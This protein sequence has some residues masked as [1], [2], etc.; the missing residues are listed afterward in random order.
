MTRPVD[1]PLI[2][3]CVPTVNRLSYLEDALVSVVQQ[4]ARNWELVVGENSADPEYG[5]RVDH[6]IATRTVGLPNSIRV[7]HQTHQLT[8][9]AHANALL[10]MAAGDY[11]LYLPDDDRLRPKC[12]EV[13]TASVKAHPGADIVFSDHWI[14]RDDG[15]IDTAASE[16][17]SARYGRAGLRPGRV[18]ENDLLPLALR[19]SIALQAE[20]LRRHMLG[21]SPFREEASRLPDFDLHLRLVQRRPALH[22][23]YCP[24]RLVEYRVHREQFSGR[25]SSAER[26]AEFHLQFLASLCSVTT[27]P[28]QSARLYRRKVAQHRA[29]LAGCYAQSRSWRRWWHS[30]VEAIDADPRWGP[31][32]LSLLRPL[33]PARLPEAIRTRFR[34]VMAHSWL[35]WRK[36]HDGAGLSAGSRS[37]HE[38]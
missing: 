17:C 33:I 14:I 38:A 21:S 25:R 29:A 23:I 1:S 28:P 19:G 22:V 8:M 3:V 15:S 5:E 31:S 6:L 13:M 27:L 30:A 7:I 36:G 18:S 37:G 12:L 10:D 20:L 35:F 32:Y 34:T 2:S 11:L 4:T 24:E 9:V 26:R 16:S